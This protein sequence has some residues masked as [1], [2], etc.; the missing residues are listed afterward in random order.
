MEKTNWI[1]KIILGIVLLVVILQIYGALMPV[2]M[3]AG[4]V[5]NNTVTTVGENRTATLPL[6]TIFAGNGVIFVIIMAALLMA[7]VYYFM[8]DMKK[9]RK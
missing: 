9:G 2:A 5:I 3:T 4:N 1:N 7:V 8:K 6:N